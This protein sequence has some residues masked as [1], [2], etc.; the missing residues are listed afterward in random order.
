V[1]PI[2][3]PIGAWPGCSNAIATATWR[4]FGKQTCW[5][6]MPD[7]NPLTDGAVSQPDQARATQGS[8]W[9]RFETLA[10]E[11]LALVI[12]LSNSFLWP[13]RYRRTF[14]PAAPSGLLRAF[15]FSSAAKA[16][17]VAKDKSDKGD[18]GFHREFLLEVEEV[19]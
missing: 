5:L 4:A 9:V 3:K 14:F 17:P 12:A 7:R 18:Q 15:F 19:W 8:G 1:P 11:L 2:R 13:V 16:P 10:H 6:Q